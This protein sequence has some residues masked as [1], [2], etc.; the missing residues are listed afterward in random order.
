MKFTAEDFKDAKPVG[1]SEVGCIDA[2]RI[3]NAKLE[4]WLKNAPEMYGV[5]TPLGYHGSK[6]VKY[7]SLNPRITHRAKLVCI[8]PLPK[9]GA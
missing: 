3:A 2:A 4:E 5:V 1:M 6:W 8:E 7:K 9:E